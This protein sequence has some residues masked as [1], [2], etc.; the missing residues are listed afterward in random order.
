MIKFNID[1]GHTAI[2]VKGSSD[3][4]ASEILM[5]NFKLAELLARILNISVDHALLFMMQECTR[6]N[7]EEKERREAHD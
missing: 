3:I 1:K 2:E 6:I 4:I 5:T 7:N